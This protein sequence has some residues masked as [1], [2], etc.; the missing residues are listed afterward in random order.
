[1]ANVNYIKA[2]KYSMRWR[3]AV[4]RGVRP[5]ANRV[6]LHTRMF[7]ES[8]NGRLS[9]LK[10]RSSHG[11]DM[12]RASCCNGNNA[13]QAKAGGASARQPK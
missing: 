11:A 8:E 5:V 10:M 13:V 2:Q 3:E 4:Y 7:P 9:L 6:L 1:M 12:P